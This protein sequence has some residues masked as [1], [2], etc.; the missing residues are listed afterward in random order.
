[1]HSVDPVRVSH[2]PPGG[3]CCKSMRHQEVCGVPCLFSDVGRP[4][5]ISDTPRVFWADRSC[6]PPVGSCTRRELRMLFVEE[7]VQKGARS[8]AVSPATSEQPCKSPASRYRGLPP[9]SGGSL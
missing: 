3:E 1:M 2:L 5:A 6:G 4:I 9:A 7:L 8:R